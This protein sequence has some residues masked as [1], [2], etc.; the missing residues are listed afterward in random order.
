[1]LPDGN[2]DDAEVHHRPQIRNIWSRP[3]TVHCP[4]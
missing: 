2:V 4:L 1:M 3:L